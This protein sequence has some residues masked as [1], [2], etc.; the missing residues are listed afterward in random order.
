AASFLADEI[1]FLH[2]SWLTDAGTVQLSYWDHREDLDHKVP[3]VANGQRITVFPSPQPE[4]P[5]FPQVSAPKGKR[6][7]P[8]PHHQWALKTHSSRNGL[9]ER[10]LRA[11][12]TALRSPFHIRNG[13][14]HH[15]S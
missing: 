2:V 4:S 12:P 1:F 7:D 10:K 3:E 6:K 14:P 9:P 13:L 5:F 8:R 11:D 15:R